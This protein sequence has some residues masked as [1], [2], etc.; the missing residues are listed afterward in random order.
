MG[1]LDK[2]ARFKDLGKANATA[3][4]K[5]LRMSFTKVLASGWDS[6]WDPIAV[7]TGQ[8]VSQSGGNGLIASG[9]T[10]NAETILRYRMQL[11]GDLNLRAKLTL[12]QRIANNNFFVELVDVLGD[13]LALTVN[14]ATSITVTL[15]SDVTLTS[16]NVGQSITVGNVKGV[17][18]A[19]PGRYA[20][21]SVSGQNVTFTVSGWPASGSGTCSLFGWNAYRTLFDG[22]VATNAKFDSYRNGYGSGDTTLT[23][24]TTASPEVIA[25]TVENG[26][27][28]WSDATANSV[29]WTPRGYRTE[30]IPEA[31]IPMVLQIRALNG[32]VAP[33]SSTTLTVGFVGIEQFDATVV[34]IGRQFGPAMANGVTI[35]N[36]VTLGAGTN[37]IGNIGTVTTVTGVTTVTT[38]TNVTN[39][40]TPTAPATPYFVNSAAS[41]NG[42]L[43]LT[44][45]SGLCALWA[46]NTGAAAAFVKLYNKATAPTVGTDVP[47]MVIPVPAA[48]GGVPG[49]VE[50]SPGV[51][52]Y[53]FALGLGI[54]I[55]GGSA[56]SDTTA[57]AAGQVKVKLSRTV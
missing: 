43:I 1:A 47:E 22:T 23:I 32:T 24:N 33:A 29:A 56:D 19:V 14:S 49:I 20:I 10:A 5:L 4:S 17:S 41:T 34:S 40:G 57:V 44:G 11:T 55:T 30:N 7:G 15:P 13:D 8:T 21:A 39:S 2:Y 42:A 35:T 6:E 3:N 9:T 37:S 28:A 51:N 36:P 48:V 12:S 52:A 18:G 26:N 25:V 31:D 27:T 46:S 38:V 54:A 16:Q 50:I 53:R 45:T